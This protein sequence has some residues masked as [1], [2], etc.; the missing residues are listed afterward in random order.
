MIESRQK[1]GRLPQKT[2]VRTRVSFVNLMGT[3]RSRRHASKL[4]ILIRKPMLYEPK[5][6]N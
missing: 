2:S 6:I 3:S 4:N 1:A 5:P